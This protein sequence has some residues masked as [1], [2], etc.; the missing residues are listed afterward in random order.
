MRLS[1]W[2]ILI[3]AFSVGM[4]CALS[5]RFFYFEATPSVAQIPEPT[6]KILFAKQ[7]IPGGVEITADF[8]IFQE[9]PLSE[10]PPGALNSFAQVH[11]RQPALAIPA[12]YPIFE[13]LLLLPTTNTAE[14]AFIPTGHQIVTLDVVQIRQGDKVSSPKEPLSA[15]LSADQRI[16]IRVVPPEI[17]G[18]LA[19]KR[20]ELLRTYGSQDM[21]NSGELVLKNIPIHRI[22]R[23]SGADFSGSIREALEL[24]LEKNE[25]D[26]LAAA[27]KKGQIRIVVYHDQ[28]N[29]L[30]PTKVAEL[31][32]PLLP[33]PLP[34]TQSMS[35][36]TPFAEHSPSILAESESVVPAERNQSATPAPADFVE[37]VVSLVQTSSQLSLADE[38]NHVQHIDGQS[39]NPSISASSISAVPLTPAAP[40]LSIEKK[41]TIRNESM[42]AFG[43][44]PFRTDSL[45]QPSVSEDVPMPSRLLS[46][47][48][49]KREATVASHST[50]PLSA[51]P[52]LSEVV[53]GFP[54]ISQT[55][56]FLP[57][58]SNV[59][60]KELPP[61]VEPVVMPPIMPS[62]LPTPT[63]TVVQEKVPA[64]SPFERRT[65]T[66]L[67]EDFGK[68]SGEE[69]QT[70]QRLLKSSGAGSQ[71]K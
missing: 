2:L 22:Q 29:Q 64:Y 15:M 37:P 10:V 30:Q 45:E 4:C 6:T 18:R 12:G 63:P 40:E 8:V 52:P 55:I 47:D 56:Q 58:G 57:P 14:N 34:L 59:R 16:D 54:R 26:R 33:A 27:T 5:I 70:P 53:M 65:Y 13:D 31:P 42:I 61:P 36:D 17:H 21:R 1:L 39:A 62:A 48:L 25:A 32:A 19:E 49:P 23:K 46:S 38:D 41:D 7:T 44:A 24:I 60:E 69:L 68:S 3:V 20:I 35:P 66:V 11:R 67:P 50:A 51:T 43:T 9:V 28:D 71:T